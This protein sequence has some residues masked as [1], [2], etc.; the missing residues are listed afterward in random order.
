MI[1][2]LFPAFIYKMR[3]PWKSINL[4][5]FHTILLALSLNLHCCYPLL[6]LFYFILQ[7]AGFMTSVQGF[8]G[9][10]G[11]KK[12]GRKK[13][14]Q[15]WLK[16]AQSGRAR[17]VSLFWFEIWPFSPSARSGVGGAGGTKEPLL[18]PPPNR[19]VA[20]RLNNCALFSYW[21]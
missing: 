17:G 12:G 14:S 15:W 10:L 6:F 7:Q 9:K 16:F 5:I 8:L 20:H 21:D 13:V 19:E 3:L 4:E 1:S 11:P 18:L 2:F